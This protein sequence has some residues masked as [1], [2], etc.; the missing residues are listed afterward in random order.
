MQRNA[1]RR[2]GKVDESKDERKGRD[3]R[4]EM[5]LDGIARGGVFFSLLGL[6][7]DGL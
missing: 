1:K 7:V 2:D 6:R 5:L 3:R 4:I